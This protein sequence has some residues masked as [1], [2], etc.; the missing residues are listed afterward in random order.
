MSMLP[1]SPWSGAMKYTPVRAVLGAV[2]IIVA[3]SVVMAP[4]EALPKSARVLW[5]SLLAAALMVMAYQFYERRIEHR[6]GNE[7]GFKG[8]PLE[9][10]IGLIGG[11]TLVAS[12]FAV[13]AAL[14]VF[15]FQHRNP[16]SVLALT[17]LSEMVLVAFFEEIVV[18]GILLKSLQQSLGNLGAVVASALLFGVAHL[19]NDGATWLSTLNVALAG[20][21]FGSAFIATERLWLCIALHIGWNFTASYV[22]SA[23]VSGHESQGGLFVG[24]LSGSDLMTGGDF[25]IEG[26]VVALITLFTGIALILVFAHSRGRLLRPP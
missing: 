17:T 14:K 16:V 9:F 5:P 3:M 1:H 20:I 24:R 18:R 12:V 11:A 13:L 10:G 7:F 23:T 6:A 2:L 25:G 15:D 19:P 4:V 26:S 22:F 8:A 21:M